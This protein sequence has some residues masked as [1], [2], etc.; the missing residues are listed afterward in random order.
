MNATE[1]PAHV[2]RAVQ[3]IAERLDGNPHQPDPSWTCRTCVGEVGWPCS[4][5]R[6]RLAEM[7]PGDWVGLSIYMGSLL[8]VALAEMPATPPAELHERFVSWTRGPQ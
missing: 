5:A 3:A 6:T 2:S 4:P 7:Y 1:R 8:I